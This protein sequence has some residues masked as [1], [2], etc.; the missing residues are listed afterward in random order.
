MATDILLADLLG[1]LARK[2][3]VIIAGAGVS[4]AAT[5]RA[6]TSSWVGLIRDGA[7]RCR[8]VAGATDAW[9]SIIESELAS[10]DVDNLLSAAEKISRRLPEG[11]YARWLR[12]T[13]GA[14]RPVSPAVPSALAAF[15]VPI[16]TTN[17]DGILELSTGL[18]AVTWM[19]P[20][21]VERVLRGEDRAII[22]VH[23]HWGDPKSVILGIR[24]YEKILGDEPTQA[25]LQALRAMHS[26]IFVGYGKGLADP[27]FGA[28]LAWARR[29]FS[30]SEYRHFRLVLES[31]KDEI[32][33]EHP[34]EDR[35]FAISYGA[36]HADLAPFLES[37]RAPVP[38][39]GP[40]AAP[41]PP[42]TASRAIRRLKGIR[43]VEIRL[44]QLFRM[45]DL[46]LFPD[47][48]RSRRFR[49]VVTDRNKL[50]RALS[51]GWK[52]PLGSLGALEPA[53]LISDFVEEKFWKVAIPDFRKPTSQ[54][55]YLLPFELNLSSR[56]AGL[57]WRVSPAIKDCTQNRQFN[58]VLRVYPPGVGLVRLSV[59]VTFVASARLDVLIGLAR[60][61][62][63]PLFGPPEGDA[64]PTEQLLRDIVDE[65]AVALFGPEG[66]LEDRRWRP[67]EVLFVPVDEDRFNPAAHTE[68]LTE[69]LAYPTGQT[70][71]TAELKGRIA[72]AAAGPHWT[73]DRVFTAASERA[74][75]A[76]VSK[77]YAAGI[78]ARQRRMRT[79]LAETWELA[80]AG[81]YATKAFADILLEIARTRSVDS[82]AEGLQY[83]SL[84]ASSFHAALQAVALARTQLQTLGAGPLMVF[85]R[86]LWTYDNPVPEAE[87][88]D[89]LAYLSEW[90]NGQ[91][92]PAEGL[93]AD[94]REIAALSKGFKTRTTAVGDS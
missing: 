20:A 91:G 16:V 17:Y 47:N 65:A 5:D 54:W 26:L 3:A 87:L 89:A 86:D 27:N 31:E 2:Q 53:A 22:H 92:Q 85:A 74:A 30:G 7:Q 14:L 6:A 36:K 57:E 25:L 81:V 88:R 50:R 43:T 55:L 82:S 49:D 48:V 79:W 29:A 45:A 13:V 15:G 19:S 37:L 63:E 83:L 35:I 77:D 68:E 24:S 41:A 32:Q 75:L 94:L 58:G 51:R 71:T 11:E 84:A 59:W 62:E 28:L 80:A 23:G 9:L 78:S 66:R 4:I 44:T 8:Q 56:L 12:E 67:P 61:L 46:L 42:A 40:A 76:F 60:H 64:A 18:P 21:A 73:R 10:G 33:G 70:E 72:A 69:L 38:A 34:P 93:R 1:I 52:M 39:P 90:A